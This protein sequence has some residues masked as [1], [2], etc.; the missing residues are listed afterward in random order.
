MK[1]LLLFLCC[2][3]PI[4]AQGQASSDLTNGLLFSQF[5]EGTVSYKDGKKIKALLNYNSVEEEMLFRNPDNSI[6]ALANPAEVTGIQ[7][8]N[9][10]FVYARKDA[11]YEQIAAGNQSFYIQWKSKLISQGKGT[12]Y[13]GHSQA[14]SITNIGSM[15]GHGADYARFNLDEIFETKTERFF[16]IKQKNSF[17]KFNSAKT[18]GKL[19]KGNEDKIEQFAKENSVDFSKTEDIEKIVAYCYTLE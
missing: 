17:K 14:S 16:Y 15:Q 3:L 12:A 19:F 6:L 1:N 10:H 11:F 9:R 8:G 5:K 7:I 13:G 4:V 18:L 2:F